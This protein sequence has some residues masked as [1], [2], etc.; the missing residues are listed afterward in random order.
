MPVTIIDK[1]VSIISYFT[2]GLAGLLWILAAYFLKKKIKFFLMYNLLQSMLIA[3][4]F[5]VINIILE[6]ILQILTIIPV[7]SGI[8][9]SLTMF[10]NEKTPLFLGLAADKI[11]MV[12]FLLLLYITAGVLIGRIFC[13][14]VLTKVMSRIMRNYK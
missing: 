9:L 2:M 3:V 6:I 8:G 11:E 4:L 13:T 14:P 1:A 5:A 10:L 7:L 12:L